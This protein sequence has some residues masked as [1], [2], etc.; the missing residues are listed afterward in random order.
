MTKAWKVPLSVHNVIVMTAGFAFHSL[1]SD[2]IINLSGF[3][4][5]SI[6]TDG[7]L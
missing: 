6:L 4:Y 2:T 5:G 7:L 1:A 3:E